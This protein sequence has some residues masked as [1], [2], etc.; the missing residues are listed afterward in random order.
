MILFILIMSYM[1]QKFIK[2][3]DEK[4]F[5]LMPHFNLVFHS[6]KMNFVINKIILKV[7]IFLNKCNRFFFLNFSTR[8]IFIILKTV[9]SKLADGTMVQ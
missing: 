7:I 6:F 5:K 3:T 4:L 9:A 2:F 8:I 1:A